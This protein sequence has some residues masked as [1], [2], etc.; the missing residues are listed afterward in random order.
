M[1]ILIFNTEQSPR[2]YHQGHSVS[3]AHG[4]AI[5]PQWTSPGPCFYHSR[6][7]LV[8]WVLRESKTRRASITGGFTHTVELELPLASLCPSEHH[9]VLTERH[10]RVSLGLHV[11]LKGN[12]KKRRMWPLLWSL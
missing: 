6:C 9:L 11:L 2:K 10:T 8:L 12:R 5:V 1:D 7:C 4:V 3:G